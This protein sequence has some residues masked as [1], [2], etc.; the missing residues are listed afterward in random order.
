MPTYPTSSRNILLAALLVPCQQ[1]SKIEEKIQKLEPGS[2]VEIFNEL[3]SLR[4]RLEAQKKSQG[5]AASWTSDDSACLEKTETQQKVL[6]DKIKT[7]NESQLLGSEAVAYYLLQENKV[8]EAQSILLKLIESNPTA[9]VPN[10]FYSWSL[11]NEKA[12]L[13]LREK[14]LKRVFIEKPKNEF[15]NEI[16]LKALRDLTV[17]IPLDVLELQKYLDI[18]VERDP[19]SKEL[20]LQRA[21]VSLKLKDPKKIEESLSNLSPADNYY[22]AMQAGR[23]RGQGDKVEDSAQSFLNLGL[24]QDPRDLEVRVIL[25][26]SLLSRKVHRSARN[27]AEKSLEKY[28]THKGLRD[29][30]VAS[31]LAGAVDDKNPIRDLEKSLLLFP[32]STQ[33]M[34]KLLDE[35]LKPARP[36][37]ETPQI[38]A[39][40]TIKQAEGLVRRIRNAKGI[41]DAH[42]NIAESWY[43]TL[44]FYKKIFSESD[45]LFAQLEKNVL[46][47]KKSPFDSAS[48]FKES[49]FWILGAKVKRARGQFQEAKMLIQKGIERSQSV[50]EKQ[51][52][53]KFL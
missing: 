32:E 5:V 21:T 2:A 7:L 14:H 26:E 53:L 36:S 12:N 4:D 19:N 11:R 18:W 40:S 42:R 28:P 31:I 50:E 1:F 47:Q 43:A 16:Q 13:S 20:W 15:E 9:L 51:I 38:P 33:L 3:N 25:I 29:L 52:L 10:Y 23:L 17:D 6:F 37:V 35:I 27:L 46:A 39:D 34:V 49:D 24:S 45:F 41:S 8:S 22:F 30:V 44:Q 48:A